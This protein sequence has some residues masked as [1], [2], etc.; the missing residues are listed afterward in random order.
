MGRGKE[1]PMLRPGQFEEAF[2]ELDALA[3]RAKF[4]L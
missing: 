1:L 2:E 3:R 4:I